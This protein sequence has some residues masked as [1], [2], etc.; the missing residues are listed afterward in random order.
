V[1]FIARFTTAVVK[2]ATTDLWAIALALKADVQPASN[3]RR[4][5]RFLSGYDLDQAALGR[6]LLHLLPTESPYTLTLDR[7]EW[8]LGQAPVNVLAVGVVFG[9]VAVPIA[10]RALPK[11]GGSGAE[12]QIR[13]LEALLDVMDAASIDVLVADRE[14]I[15]V[16]WLRRLQDE[17]VSFAIRLRSDRQV[18]R[19]P[20]GVPTD[21]VPADGVPADGAS[22][23]G[24]LPVRLFARPTGVGEQRTLES[25][26]LF[27]EEG[28]LSVDLVIQRIGPPSADD[29]F[30]ILAVWNVD[31][32][33][34]MDVYSERWSIETLFA[35][36]KSRGFDLEETHVTVPA[37]V[38]RLI[39]LLALAFLWARLIGERRTRREGPPRRTTHGRRQ[40]SVFRYGLDRLRSI[41]STPKPQPAAFV[42]CLRLLRSP[43]LVLSCT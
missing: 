3:H 36:L 38:E 30:V 43:T 5:Q 39:G 21:G 29:P 42:D 37:R 34:A 41:L 1:K 12:D 19:A 11:G 22:R 27:G 9:R 4:I 10:W 18:A 14:F 2:Q 23:S 40:R 16:R 20:D 24:A 15:S 31:S 17:G 25:V 8:H 13:L 33:R 28:P 32:S 26:R 6:L 7:T 35:A